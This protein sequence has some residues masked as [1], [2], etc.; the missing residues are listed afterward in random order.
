MA[1]EK[2]YVDVNVFVYWLANHPKFGETSHGWIKKI[3]SSPRGEYVT[4]S[5]SLYEILVIIAGLTG[6]N[7]KDKTFIEE[8]IKIIT[9]IKALT[10]EPLEQKDFTFAIDLMSDYKLDYEDALHLSVATRTG[11]QMIISN[12]KHFA[13]TPIKGIF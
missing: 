2:R 10:I 5:I 13:S 1:Q 4:S 3:E 6:K 9:Q 8:V 7:L 11:A 12:D